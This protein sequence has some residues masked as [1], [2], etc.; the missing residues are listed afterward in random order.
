VI[1]FH[2]VELHAPSELLCYFFIK[3]ETNI[4]TF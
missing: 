4:R 2:M 3:P 1:P